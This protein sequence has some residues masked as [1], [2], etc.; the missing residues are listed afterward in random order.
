VENETNESVQTEPPTDL[1]PVPDV[2]MDQLISEI[3]AG[4]WGRGQARRER[5]SNAGHNVAAV[6]EAY[7]KVI[8]RR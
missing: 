6:D 8:N 5:L 2:S 4:K 3:L 7:K 1:D